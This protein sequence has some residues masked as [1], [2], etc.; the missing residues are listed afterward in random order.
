MCIF[1]LPWI[2]CSAQKRTKIVATRHDFWAQN[3]PKMLLRS[4]DSLAGL[5]RGTGREGEERGEGKVKGW[6]EE[7]GG[8]RERGSEERGGREGER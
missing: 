4:P 3:V 5:G 1:L 2:H 7:E 6:R 8:G